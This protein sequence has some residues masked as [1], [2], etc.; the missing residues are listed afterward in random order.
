M[1]RE[2]LA[3]LGCELVAICDH[4][5]P[6]L[7][8][9]QEEVRLPD[10]CFFLDYQDLL[11]QVPMDAVLLATPIPVHA[12]QAV[13]ALDAGISVLSEVT[14]ANTIEG[15]ASII[16]AARRSGRTYMLAENCLYWPFIQDFAR[17]VH[18]GRLG[19][20]V[21]AEAE[22]LHPIPELLI[23]PATRERRWR[24]ARPPL[25]YCT[26]SLG[27]LLEI[28]QDRV[29][30]AMGLGAEKRIMPEAGVGGIDV[31]VALFETEKHA[32]IKLL[33]TQVA[34]RHPAMHYYN[35]QGTRGFVESDRT[36]GGKGLLWVKGEMEGVQEIECQTTNPCLPAEMVSAHGTSDYELVRDFVTLLREGRRPKIDEVR[37]WELTVPGLLAA[38]SAVRGGEWL[39]VPAPPAVAPV[40]AC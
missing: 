26:H 3:T 28:M 22:Y 1:F 8:Q 35:L 29:T 17:I 39:E 33:R 16:A 38:E 9:S 20:I 31:Q 36:L 32:I 13:A 15:C 2:A 10:S 12:E 37:A 25:H 5:E 24:D 7:A 40:T 18:S 11:T 21:Y 27:P 6:A 14:A 30:R 4:S 34:P 23:D 19:D